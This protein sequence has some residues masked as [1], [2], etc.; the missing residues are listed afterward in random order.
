MKFIILRAWEGQ[1]VFVSLEHIE[2]I[3]APSKQGGEYVRIRTPGAELAVKE[4]MSEVCDK[5]QLAR[6]D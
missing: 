3:I 5:I 4:T 2:C 6:D 1:E